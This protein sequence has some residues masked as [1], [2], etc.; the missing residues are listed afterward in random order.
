MTGRVFVLAAAFAL[1]FFSGCGR[2]VPVITNEPVEIVENPP[3]QEEITPVPEKEPEA[4]DMVKVEPSK[5]PA[6]TEIIIGTKE[7]GD[8]SVR[9]KNQTGGVI[10][11]VYLRTSETEDWGVN[12]AEE[13]LSW[14][15]G[16][17]AVLHVPA[18]EINDYFYYDLSILYQDEKP[19]DESWFRLLPLSSIE[20]LVLKY[21]TLNG[22]PVPYVEYQEKGKTGTVSTYKDVLSRLGIEDDST[23]HDTYFQETENTQTESQTE[24]LDAPS[25]NPNAEDPGQFT[26]H[27]NQVW[28]PT[29]RKQAETYIGMD[30]NSLL[31]D[32]GM[33]SPN[34]T[35]YSSDNDMG[36]GGFYYFDGFTVITSIDPNGSETVTQIW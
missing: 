35:S 3:Q 31:D 21:T 23:K 36:E 6:E 11:Q 33:G 24:T 32:P 20:E 12:R 5:T 18:A 9:I 10:E 34:D 1:C 15:D 27:D 28:D 14:K 25:D 2:E 19:T 16:Q 4:V 22:V 26:G 8:F 29:L 13:T 17:T 7:E 30:I